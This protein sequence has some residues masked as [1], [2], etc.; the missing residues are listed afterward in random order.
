MLVDT[1][2]RQPAP[3][4]AVVTARAPAVPL[5][6][7]LVATSG[8]ATTAA[9][10]KTAAALA[11]I[12]HAAVRVATFHQPPI[13]HPTSELGSPASPIAPSERLAAD[14]QLAEVRNQLADVGQDCA[15]WPITIQAGHAAR[16][17]SCEAAQATDLIVLG[18]GRR[19]PA[20]RPLGDRTV[21]GV[22][23]TSNIPLLAVAPNGAEAPGKMLVAVG[24]DDNVVEAARRAHAIFPAP[25]EIYLVHVRVPDQ[26]PV[27]PESDARIAE[28]FRVVRAALAP[29]AGVH[30]ETVIVEGEPVSELLSFARRTG[31]H[32][33]VGGL[34]GVTV[35][36]RCMM[37]N[38]ALRV[39]NGAHCSVLL[40]P[41]AGD[42]L[43]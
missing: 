43:T 5:R 33:I 18:I 29:S 10:V 39:L 19:L 30:V 12:H 27:G 16:C 7:I 24:L 20:D 14:H 15:E 28:Q 23:L 17:I 25:Q 21:I 40:V 35:Y 3:R 42:D 36:E 11:R 37:R 32:L 13:P 41:G 8:N 2:S 6:C 34:H 22:A 9:A 31:V 38:I 26:L 1:T 4:D